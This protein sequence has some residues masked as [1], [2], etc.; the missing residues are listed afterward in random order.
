MK[1]N[2]N[3]STLER[4][5][6]TITRK[7]LHTTAGDYINEAKTLFGNNTLVAKLHSFRERGNQG[8]KL[9]IHTD[10]SS[11]IELEL[12]IFAVSGKLAIDGYNVYLSD[13]A[14]GI[15][16]IA[17]ITTAL[18]AR[19]KIGEL[20]LEENKEVTTADISNLMELWRDKTI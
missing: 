12:T 8:L 11:N 2:N 13:M 6:R 5:G 7:D 3:T 4:S 16:L 18:N 14:E 15:H 17:I 10:K 1:K 20:R 19:V 9:R